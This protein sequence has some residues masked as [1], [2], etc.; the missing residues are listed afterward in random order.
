M[1]NLMQKKIYLVTGHGLIQV[2]PN[3]IK[4]DTATALGTTPDKLHPGY[5]RDSNGYLI[6]AGYIYN[7]TAYKFL[8]YADDVQMY[9][10]FMVKM[11]HMQTRLY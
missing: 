1:E 8:E 7:M 3:H 5:I 2:R 9:Y 11:S 6:L 10:P 4:L